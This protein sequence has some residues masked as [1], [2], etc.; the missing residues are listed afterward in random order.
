M[1]AVG[2]RWVA[3]RERKLVF[4]KY[5]CEEGSELCVEIL[6]VDSKGVVYQ[7]VNRNTNK[8]VRIGGNLDFYRGFTV[9]T[10]ALAATDSVLIN[11]DTSFDVC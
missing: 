9:F 2:Q 1:L 11:P 10:K 5:Y 3:H 6:K 8:P 4:S 7:Y